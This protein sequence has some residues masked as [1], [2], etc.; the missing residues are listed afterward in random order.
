M[1]FADGEAAA[2][3]FDLAIPPGILYV[4][5]RRAVAESRGAVLFQTALRSLESCSSRG[6]RLNV[7]WR[8]RERRCITLYLRGMPAA[9]AESALLAAGGRSR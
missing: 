6:R 9:A 3:S 4:T 2:R 7:V 8:A 1:E 5:D